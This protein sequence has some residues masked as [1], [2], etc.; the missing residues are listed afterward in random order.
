MSAKS[1]TQPVCG[2]RSP[3]T[4]SSMR[5]E[6][7]C[8][9]AHLWPAG[10][11][12]RRCAASMVKTRKMFICEKGAASGAFRLSQLQKLYAALRRRELDA[13]LQVPQVQRMPLQSLQTV[14]S[15]EP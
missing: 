2:S 3:E 15:T 8:R 11:F 5:N 6:C 10:T 1:I 13:Q 4:C 12:G 14:K 9:R 7:P